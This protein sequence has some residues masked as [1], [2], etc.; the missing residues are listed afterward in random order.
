[1]IGFNAERFDLLLDIIGFYINQDGMR[2]EKAQEMLTFL[3]ASKLAVVL[4]GGDL[5]SKR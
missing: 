4:N 2:K 3:E 5:K 1:M